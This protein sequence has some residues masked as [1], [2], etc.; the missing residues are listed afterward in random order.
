MLGRWL[1]TRDRGSSACEYCTFSIG[2]I[3]EER[4]RSTA[5]QAGPRGPEDAAQMGGETD[6]VVNDDHV[7]IIRTCIVRHTGVLAIPTSYHAKLLV[8]PFL[9]C[10]ANAKVDLVES[11][12]FDAGGT[13]PATTTIT[14]ESPRGYTD[15]SNSQ[16]PP[17][18]P[19]SPLLSP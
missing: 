1:G 7:M 12:Y 6:H 17:T 10:T 9:L 13:L 3:R 4:G 11:Q 2:L 14:R 18:A 8:S 16:Q 15:P 5:I 19:P